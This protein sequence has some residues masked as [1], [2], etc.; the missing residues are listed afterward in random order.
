MKK[1]TIVL[2]VLGALVLFGGMN[3]CSRYN[4][5]S[6]A[7]EDV[8][9]S[10]GQVENVYQRR[11]DLIPQLV[12]TIQGYIGHENKTLVGVVE[13]RASATKITIDPSNCTPEQLA[14]YS[15][16]QGNLTNALGKLMM[17][18]EAYPDLKANDQFLSLQAEIAGSENRIAVERQKFNKIVKTYNKKL[19]GVLG[20]FW[21]NMFGFEKRAY[22]EASQGANVAPVI[23]FN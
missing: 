10:W 7:E 22:F 8:D 17:V 23:K 5:M 11:T 4:G 3:G 15:N 14:A 2:L 16:A 6:Y 9:E 20:K 1:S 21:S 19:L 18:T 12:S 13:A